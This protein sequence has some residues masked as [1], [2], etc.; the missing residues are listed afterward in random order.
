MKHGVR[1]Q[2]L[3]TILA[4]GQFVVARPLGPKDLDRQVTRHGI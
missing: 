4:S 3:D 2:R 1:R